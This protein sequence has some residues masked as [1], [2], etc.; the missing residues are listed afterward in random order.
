MAADRLAAEL[1]LFGTLNRN[2]PARVT[3]TLAISAVGGIGAEL[4]GLPAG[5][6][7]GGLLAVAAASLAGVNTDIPR[8]MRAPIYLVLGVYA[9]GG[10]SQETLHQMQ[11][12]PASFAILGLSLVALIAGSYRWLNGRCGWDRNAALLSSLP[13][14]LSFV[15]AAAEG[16]K[17]DMKKVT[18]AQSIRLLILIEMIPLIALVIGQPVGA[19]ITARNPVAGPLDLMILLVAGLV[20]ATIMERLRLAGGW[21]LGGLLASAVLLLTGLVNARLPDLLVIPCMMGLAAIAGSRFRPGDL[22]VLPH[23][24]WPALGA[25]AIAS[26]VSIVSAVAVSL[27]FDINIIQTLLAFAPGALDAL[28]VLAYQMNIDPAYVAAHHVVRFVALVVAVPLIA[29]WLSRP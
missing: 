2:Y 26:L 12:W 6:I 10:V 29:R 22:A 3:M 19:P 9:G 24:A 1:T 4:M 21:M 5:W 18:I 7:S 16:L 17:A 20:A 8:A 27:L 15:M 28:T 14:A 13:G 25:F 11:T 23:I